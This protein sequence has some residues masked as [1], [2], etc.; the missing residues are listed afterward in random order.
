MGVVVPYGVLFRGGQEGEIRKGIL[1]DDLIEAV[2]GLPSRLFYGTG[3][4]AALFVIL[5]KAK[6]NGRKGK[7]ALH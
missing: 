2:I 7:G 1:E 4:P 3:I 6:S 5:N